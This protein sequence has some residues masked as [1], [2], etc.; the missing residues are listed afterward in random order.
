VTA[1][2]VTR[3]ARAAVATAGTP[4]NNLPADEIN[5]GT[6]SYSSAAPDATM[7][8][9]AM[10]FTGGMTAAAS[11]GGF[12]HSNLQPYLALNYC[13]ATQGVFPPRS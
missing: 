13:I 8:A 4:V 7:R 5:A 10:A 11:G 1:L 6:V 12:P 3:K 2:T 9:G